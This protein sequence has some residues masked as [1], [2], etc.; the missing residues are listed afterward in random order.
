MDG[1]MSMQ[2]LNQKELQ[3]LTVKY[4]LHFHN[5]DWLLIRMIQKLKRLAVLFG[6]WNWVSFDKDIWLIID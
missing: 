4:N 5:C 6:D 3:N 1:L 2:I